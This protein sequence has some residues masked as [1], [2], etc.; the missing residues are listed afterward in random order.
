LRSRRE[1]SSAAVIGDI[2]CALESVTEAFER[3]YSAEEDDEDDV[4]EDDEKEKAAADAVD[5]KKEKVEKS[6]L[7]VFVQV[8]LLM[9]R[10]VRLL[11]YASAGP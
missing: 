1:A 9:D 10:W 11:D 8:Q 5:E 2:H 4:E 6:V 3:E 7:P